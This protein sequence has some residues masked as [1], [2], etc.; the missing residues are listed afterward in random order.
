M[1]LFCKLL[2]AAGE[3]SPP[4]CEGFPLGNRADS[5]FMPASSSRMLGCADVAAV[6]DAMVRDMADMK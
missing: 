4:F 5:M 3:R 6:G 1:A 2:K